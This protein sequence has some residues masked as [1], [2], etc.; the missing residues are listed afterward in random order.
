MTDKAQPT[1]TPAAVQSVGGLAVPGRPPV[2]AGAGAVPRGVVGKV[3]ARERPDALPMPANRRVSALT[4]ASVEER[5]ADQAAGVRAVASGDNVITMFDDIGEGFWTPGVTAR[6]V[7]AQLRAIGERPIEVQINSPGGDMFEGIAIYNVLREHPQ[8]I[9]VKVMGMAASAASVIAMAGDTIEIGAASF[10]MI[11]DCSVV[12]MGNRQAMLDIAA[13]LQPFDEAM[14]GL[15]ARR[16]GQ[17]EQ[18]ISDW[19]DAETWL[20]GATAIAKGFADKLLPADQITVDEKTKAADRAAS[21]I[22]ATEHALISSGL[23]RAQ[24]RARLNIIKGKPD[25]AH[26]RDKPDAVAAWTRAASSTLAEWQATA[27]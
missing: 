17:T 24:A 22:R 7:S 19:M 14:V 16:T 18:Q 4:P 6:G 5:W 9:T 12:A 23:T 21:E 2:S 20:S 1:G 27:A 8:P 26:D 13:W 11:H 10:F 25:A 3:Q 15:Y